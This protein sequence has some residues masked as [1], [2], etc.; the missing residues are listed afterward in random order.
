MWSTF[1][2]G[3][4]WPIAATIAIALAI[5]GLVAETLLQARQSNWSQASLGA[6]N[7]ARAVADEMGR[8]IEGLG[9]SLKALAENSQ[10]PGVMEL[11]TRLRDMAL[12]ERAATMRSLGYLLLL[13][14]RGGITATA[15]PGG[16]S[17][18]NFADR[19]YFIAHRASPNLGLLVGEPF[20]SRITGEQIIAVSRR[21]TDADGA[22]RGVAIGTLRLDAVRA[23]FSAIQLG[24]RDSMS[25]FHHDGALAMRVPYRASV[26]GSD[27]STSEV[28]RQAMRAAAGQF[29]AVSSLDGIERLH[30]YAAVPNAPLRIA[31]SLSVADMERDWRLHTIL[32]STAAATLIGLLLVAGFALRRELLRRRAAE[33][34]VK[35]SEASFRLLAE[36]SA[37][38]VVRVDAQGIRRYVSPASV[39]V[40]GRSPEALVGQRPLEDIHPHDLEAVLA[41]SK[42]LHTGGAG[43]TTIVYR[44][45]RSDGSWIW[46][47]STLRAISD[48][49]DG[50]P[51][52]VI[53][54]SRDV[55]ERK[56]AEAELARMATL[57]GLTNLHNRRCFDE[58]LTREWR[59]CA[60]AEL[61]LSLLLVDVDRFKA[62]NDSQGHQRGDECLRA[63]AAVLDGTVRRASDLAARYG[64]E[65]FALLLP[66][67]DGLGA[68]AVAARVRAEVEALALAHPASEL[69]GGV[70]TVSV[71]SST[72]WPVPGQEESGPPALVG[73]ADEALYKAKQTGRNRAVH[74]G[75]LP[76]LSS[77]RAD[78]AASSM[79]LAR[80]PNG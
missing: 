54:V 29:V 23:L 11:P 55:T 46:L 56:K 33:V 9:L 10:V 5:S 41:A 50:R 32:V 72:L 45:R 6:R 42:L 8:T 74:N 77:G 43:E 73:A 21:V 62:L 64:G 59:R 24:P 14:E 3:D 52:G 22:F 44:T 17:P 78:D 79:N 1:R 19:D 47:E 31:V 7:L 76:A 27:V 57:D 48:P 61:P 36:N 2:R 53:A 18:D 67:T 58:T 35:E 65:E 49:G 71:G 40:L 39:R 34:A 12:F 63:V 80:T 37:D 30:A 51:D 28:Y 60:R 4:W 75:T 38:M 16:P 26:I 20:R 68:E 70:I 66:E 25:M 13:D 69:A 15:R